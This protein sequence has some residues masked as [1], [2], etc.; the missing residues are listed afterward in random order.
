MAKKHRVNR[1]KRVQHLIRLEKERDAY[2]AKRTRPKRLR[3]E[4][5]EEAEKAPMGICT[6][7]SDPQ[8]SQIQHK[9]HR[10]EAG[11]LTHQKNDIAHVEKGA[12]MRSTASKAEASSE[13]IAPG[14]K[15]ATKSKKVARRY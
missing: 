6:R 13:A 12:A 1:A 5:N 8:A 10:A 11:E 4:A 2:L 7:S 15:T 14:S 3:D 9:K